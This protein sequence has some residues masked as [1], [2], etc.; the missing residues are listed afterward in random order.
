MKYLP[1]SITLVMFSKEKHEPI[2]LQE[3][4][5]GAK[6]EN[7]NKIWLISHSLPPDIINYVVKKKIQY[8]RIVY[9]HSTS[10]TPQIQY[11]LTDLSRIRD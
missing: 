3:I 8:T 5:I 9:T 7:L 10:Q 4:E 11:S 6:F 2:K 1:H